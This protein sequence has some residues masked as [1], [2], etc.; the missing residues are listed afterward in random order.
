MG[1]ALCLFDTPDG[2]DLAEE[3]IIAV[4]LWILDGIANHLLR[5]NPDAVPD[6]NISRALVQ[7]G[8]VSII[9]AELPLLKFL[10]AILCQDL[11]AFNPWFCNRI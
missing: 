4:C 5:S 9:S 11:A 6:A 8:L 10:S 2:R 3:A 7:L 1:P